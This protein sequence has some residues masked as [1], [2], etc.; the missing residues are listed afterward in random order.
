MK[1][2]L[3]RFTFLSLSLS[4]SLMLSGCFVNLKSHI[5]REVKVEISGDVPVVISNTGNSNFT[6]YMN[7]E[8]Y[9]NA[10]LRGVKGELGGTEN[11]IIVESGG[12]F[13]VSFDQLKVME[14]TKI[15]KID[16]TNSDD[17]GKEF[18]LT[19]LN[20]SATGKVT[21]VSDGSTRNWS[22]YKDKSESTTSSRSAGQV[23]TGD[24]KDKTE[25]REKAFDS[26]TAEDLTEKTGRRSGVVLVRDIGKLLK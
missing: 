8:Q 23:L 14:S 13:L 15:E 24:N 11:V 22:A 18:E 16:D 19:T 25:Y 10:F 7:Q 5:N 12:E 2:R 20:L 3:E 9:V 6:T 1:T 4:I 26:G 21:R 17:H